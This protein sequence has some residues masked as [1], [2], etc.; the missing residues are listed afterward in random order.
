MLHCVYK[1]EELDVISEVGSKD[2]YIAFDLCISCE[3]HE[4]TITFNC[5][6][7]FSGVLCVRSIE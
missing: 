4:S 3:V 6:T 7:L 1:D 5:K 2:K